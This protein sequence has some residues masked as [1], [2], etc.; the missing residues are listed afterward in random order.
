[1]R[2]GGI[3]AVLIGG[4]LLAL[5]IR[6]NAAP[7]RTA[8]LTAE[9]LA[10]YLDPQ[11]FLIVDPANK[12]ARD[13]EN[14]GAFEFDPWQGFGLY[15][16]PA[17]N[18]RGAGD[19]D[20][21][22][23]ANEYENWQPSQGGYVD[24][25]GYT[26]GLPYQT[27]PEVQMPTNTVSEHQLISLVADHLEGEEGFRDHIYDD[28]NG[29]PWSQSRKGNPTIGFGHMVTKADFKRYGEG[30]RLQDYNE[31]R[32]LLEKDVRSHLA[33]VVPVV[34]VPLTVPQWVAVASLAFN[35]GPTAVAESRF[36]QAVNAGDIQ[37][38]ELQFKDWNKSSVWVDGVK[39]KRVNKGLVNRRAR[40]WAI[41][42]TPAETVAIAGHTYA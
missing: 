40:E 10:M 33:P 41:F 18:L 32:S 3:V 37:R 20:W 25:T 5:A 11:G 27:A 31:A 14:A 42:T 39:I 19:F 13:S 23:W 7:Y 34:K 15:G 6:A 17:G 16:A 38:A 24:N 1:M 9:E 8:E 29:R 2:A 26:P 30:W 35:A 21:G 4:G 36:I 22:A 12:P 28:F